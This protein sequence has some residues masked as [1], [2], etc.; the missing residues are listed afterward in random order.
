M[1]PR[2]AVHFVR[3]AEVRPRLAEARQIGSREMFLHVE[4]S[5][6]ARWMDDLFQQV[7]VAS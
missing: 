7:H 1:I 6:L 5:V 2:H 4:V 3:V